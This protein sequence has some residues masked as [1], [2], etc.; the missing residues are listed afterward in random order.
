MLTLT[1]SF[2]ILM[3]QFTKKAVKKCPNK[4]V[5]KKLKKLLTLWKIFGILLMRRDKNDK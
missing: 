5:K 3:E 4:N 2:V 1:S